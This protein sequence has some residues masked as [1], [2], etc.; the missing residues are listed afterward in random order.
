MSFVSMTSGGGRINANGVAWHTA[1]LCVAT[2][3]FRYVVAKV[4]QTGRLK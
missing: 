3:S 1:S 2:Y 4:A